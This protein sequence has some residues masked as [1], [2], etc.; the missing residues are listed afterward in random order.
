[1]YSTPT[2]TPFYWGKILSTSIYDLVLLHVCH[3]HHQG[4]RYNFIDVKCLK[5]FDEP[6]HHHTFW[7]FID[8]RD[9]RVFILDPCIQEF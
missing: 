9:T 6:H 8:F 2:P 7:Q 1:M 4:I 3:F 5:R